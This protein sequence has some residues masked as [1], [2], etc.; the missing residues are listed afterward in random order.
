MRKEKE[1]HNVSLSDCYANLMLTASLKFLNL[2][3]EFAVVTRGAMHPKHDSDSL[4]AGN[5]SISWSFL[6]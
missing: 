1:G 2:S 3:K 6:E 4:S 5:Y